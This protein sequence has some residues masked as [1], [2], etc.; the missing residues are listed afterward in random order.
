MKIKMIEAMEK[1]TEQVITDIVLQTENYGL[2]KIE[3]NYCVSIDKKR[4]IGIEISI[5]TNAKD[6]VK[7][8][9]FADK[10]KRDIDKLI[11]HLKAMNKA[12]LRIE[13]EDGG[14]YS[15]EYKNIDEVNLDDEPIFIINK[16]IAEIEEDEDI[17]NI[18]NEYEAAIKKDTNFV[19]DK[20]QLDLLSQFEIDLKR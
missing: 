13:Y 3:I 2:E 11:E 9:D 16:F 10:Y 1:L 20:E 7:G 19:F 15:K 5:K 14:L 8:R 4:V 6:I 18:S 17:I 12:S